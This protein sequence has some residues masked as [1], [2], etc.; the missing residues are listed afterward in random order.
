[1][2]SIL[3]L[4]ALAVTTIGA[5]AVAPSQQPEPYKVVFD[6]TSPDPVN[7]QAVLRWIKEISTAN[8]GAEMEVV[9][10]GHGLDLVV[11]GKSSLQ[12]AV[13]DATRTRASKCVRSP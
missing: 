2:K 6:L 4:A 8:P 13:E 11:A 12:S 5:V 10:Y 9:M 1:M 7:Q 3:C